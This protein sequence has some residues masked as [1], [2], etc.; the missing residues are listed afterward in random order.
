M[1]GSLS[2]RSRRALIKP[3]PVDSERTAGMAWARGRGLIAS[4][5][6][7]EGRQHV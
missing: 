5:L 4:S 7:G 1:F 2:L 6:A 3:E